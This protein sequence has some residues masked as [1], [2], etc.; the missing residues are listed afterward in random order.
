MEQFNFGRLVVRPTADSDITTIFMRA[1]QRVDQRLES[2]TGLADL[3]QM[4]DQGAVSLVLDS[5]LVAVVTFDGTQSN[6][7]WYRDDF[8]PETIQTIIDGW[9]QLTST[10]SA[11]RTAS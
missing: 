1:D 9:M 4:A 2:K 3:Y 6:T 10:A 5:R 11:L 7:F 8:Q